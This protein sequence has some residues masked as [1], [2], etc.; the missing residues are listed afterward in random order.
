MANEL[1]EYLESLGLRDEAIQKATELATPENTRKDLGELGGKVKAYEAE[2]AE[3]RPLKE[4]PQRKAALEKFGHDYDKA[5]KYL[6]S[7]FDAIPADK[8]DDEEFVSAH[9]R[10]NDVEV[11]ATSDTPPATTD[12]AAR[13]D[14]ALD[15]GRGAP[16]QESYEAAIAAAQSPEELD[17]V[18]AQFGKKVPQR[19]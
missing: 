13:V 5:P 2:L 16:A 10:E 1:R 4:A 8:L 3:L 17:A 14:G 15:A 7:V 6:R 19:S 12:A 11:K 18:Y 9:L